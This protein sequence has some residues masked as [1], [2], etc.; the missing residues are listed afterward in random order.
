MAI[1]KAE[2]VG[3]FATHLS[4]SKT[5]SAALFNLLAE[6]AVSELKHD[7]HAFVLPG[8][9]RILTFKRRIRLSPNAPIYPFSERKS[10]TVF[11]L[12]VAKV[13]KDAVSIELHNVSSC[14]RLGT[15]RP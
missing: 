3:R 11:K 1:T 9:G 4:V 10:R 15:T 7:H 2:L 6:I 5:K 13:M 14:F 8:I 12:R